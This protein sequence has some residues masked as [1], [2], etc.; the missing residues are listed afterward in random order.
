MPLRPC[1]LEPPDVELLQ[2]ARTEVEAF[3]IVYARY[4]QV[5]YRFARAMTGSPDAAE[6]ITQDVFV[7]LLVDTGR[8]SPDRAAF[9]TYLYGIVRNLSR[10]RLRRE[11][12]LRAMEAVGLTFGH[13]EHA[14]DPFQMIEGAELAAQVRSALARLPSRYRELI[15]LC[16]LHGLSYADT[17]LIVGTSIGAVRSRLH[18]ARQLLRLRLVHLASAETRPTV[19]SVR[20]AI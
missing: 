10:D 8:Y 7:A 1:H 5:V 20:C 12:R 18:R 11:R 9:T 19:G 16:D 2:R 17:A 14:E 15:I 13:G 3:A 6:D 4:Q